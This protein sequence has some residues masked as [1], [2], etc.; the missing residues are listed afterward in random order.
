MCDWVCKY[1][2]TCVDRCAC[3]GQSGDVLDCSPSYILRQDLLLEPELG[4]STS[5]ASQL[6]LGFPSCAPRW[7]DL[8][9]GYQTAQCLHGSCGPRLHT[10]AQQVLYSLTQ[11]PDPAMPFRLNNRGEHDGACPEHQHPL[12]REKQ[13][14]WYKFKA[15]LVQVRQSHLTQTK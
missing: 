12:R 11:L 13:K 14:Y 3:G 6:G 4:E 10:P 1:E 15:S 9:T 7:W 8:Q 5:P 2:C